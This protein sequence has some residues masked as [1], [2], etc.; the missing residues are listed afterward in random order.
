LAFANAGEKVWSDTWQSTVPLRHRNRR[1]RLLVLLRRLPMGITVG[2]DKCH[3]VEILHRKTLAMLMNLGDIDIGAGDRAYARFRNRS[4]EESQ[5][6]AKS[7]HDNC[8]NSDGVMG[9]HDGA[10]TFRGR[11]VPA[12]FSRELKPAAVVARVIP[13]L[14][15]RYYSSK[16]P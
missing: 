9:A 14:Q 6:Q 13:A 5:L 4:R 3:I 15:A 11:D 8:H 12:H 16:V 10:P 1:W 7:D 2:K